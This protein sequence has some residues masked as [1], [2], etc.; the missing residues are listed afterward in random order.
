MAEPTKSSLPNDNVSKGPQGAPA[1]G[2]NPPA[3]R[4]GETDYD[5][6]ELFKELNRMPFFMTELPE[7][8]GEENVLVEALKS[9]AYEGTRDQIAENFKNQGNEAVAEKRWFDA[10]EFYTKALAALKG[11]KIP[12]HLEDGNPMLKVVELE[13]DETIEKKERALEEACLA[14]RALCQLEMKNYGS[15][16]RDCASVLKL[17]ARSV[18]AWY[19]AASACLALDKLT[20]ALDAA[21][22]GLKFDAS[23]KPLEILQLR[24]AKRIQHVAELEQ[25]RKEREERAAREK[26][27]LQ[28]ALRSRNILV[29]T[30][31]NPPD[32]E[33]AAITL[34]DVN[35]PKS[36]LSFPIIFL[37]PLEAQSDFV[38][39]CAEDET[40]GDHMEY[41]LPPPWDQKVEYAPEETE[42][43]M[44]T[45][46][47]GLI[48]AGK[49]LILLKL[50]SGGKIEVT[51]GLVKVNIVP[52]SKA[53]TFIEEFKKRKGKQ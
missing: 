32:M 53:A 6:D 39:A 21:D 28:F 31:P 11:P 30:T 49:K 19:R 1:A 38:K 29:R 45:V 33:D 14:N 25:W 34:A 50:L 47:G 9:M 3:Q 13:D 10:R 17:N 23:S 26:S 22:C 43:Y 46:S 51:D 8:D 18:K 52:K 48:K 40:L 37:Y 5:P 35:D 15:C 12:S 16:N 27:N 20:E 42:C 36:V 24:I 2:A 4:D 44:E 7:E 41:I